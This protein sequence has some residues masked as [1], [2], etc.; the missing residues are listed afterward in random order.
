MTG[1]PARRRIVLATRNA[2]KVGEIAEAL[3]LPDVEL[4]GLDA[5]PRAP[6]VA[7]E[8]AVD[9]VIAPRRVLIID[10]RRDAM[11]PLSKILEKEGHTV[12]TA[13][14]GPSGL[15]QAAEFRPDV[16]L[17]DIGLAGDM[18]GY[19]VSRAL[20]RMPDASQAYLVAVTGYGLEED[21][22]KAK[23]AGFDYH[24]T[25]PLGKPQLKKLLGR[26]PR[27]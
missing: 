24:V 16:V 2:H 1:G 7:E 4:V 19:E 11:V 3:A 5:F 17:C 12:A 15:A 6:D 27:F 21:R 13:M 9:E 26:M 20:R 23:E 25:K 10:D 8:E 14:D 18:N 22:R